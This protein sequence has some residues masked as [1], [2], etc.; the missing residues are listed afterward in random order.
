MVAQTFLNTF[1]NFKGWKCLNCG[2]VVEKKENSL[3][4]NAF[5]LFYQRQRAKDQDE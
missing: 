3:K 5:S 4:E 2:K 1:I